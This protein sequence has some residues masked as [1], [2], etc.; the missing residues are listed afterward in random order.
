MPV[1][2]VEWEDVLAAMHAWVVAGS[3]LSDQRVRWGQQDAP[4]S[5]AASISLRLSNLSESGPMWL[6]FETNVLEFDDLPILAADV[7]TNVLHIAAHGRLT[8]DGP[9]RVSST[10]AVPGGLDDDTDY[11]VVRISANFLKLAASFQDAMALS[12]V[13]VDLT[14][15]GSGDLTLGAT[16]ETVR[17]GSELSALAR[18]TLNVTLELRCHAT[19][20][21]S[22][23]MAVAIL[24][25]VRGRREWPSQ[26]AILAEANIALQDVD[27]I[28][29]ISGTRDDFLFE[30]R[31]LMFVHLSIPVEEGETLT[32]IERVLVTNQIPDPEVEF[33]IP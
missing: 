5:D 16:S 8:G 1:G 19:P 3:G 4:R 20:V 27:R 23:E 2:G 21:I 28:I 33:E 14:D 10:G 31:A 22:G 12:P 26:Q 11:W 6:D 9:V 30:P 24:Q 32:L 25:R 18:G 13:V 17:A 7:P 15:A 29:A